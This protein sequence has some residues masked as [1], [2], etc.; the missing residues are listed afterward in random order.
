VAAPMWWWC[1]VVSLRCDSHGELCT[2]KSRRHFEAYAHPASHARVKMSSNGT[3]EGQGAA[4]M[5]RAVLSRGWRAQTEIP[6]VVVEQVVR[7][8]LR[9]SSST[10]DYAG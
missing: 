10:T 1:A 5:A 6:D 8:L 3:Q 4:M 9:F 7:E 2:R